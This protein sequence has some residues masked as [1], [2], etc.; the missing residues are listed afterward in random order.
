MAELTMQPLNA[1]F[2]LCIGAQKAGTVWLGSY[3]FTHPQ[4]WAS[5]VRALHHFDRLYAPEWAPRFADTAD[6]LLAQLARA[7]ADLEAVDDVGERQRR[8]AAVQRKREAV[9]AVAA[10]AT[11]ED[12]AEANRSYARYFADRV[13]PGC[14][15]CGEVTPSYALVPREGYEAI[16]QTFPDARFVFVLRDPVDRFWSGMQ[17]EPSRG[18]RRAEVADAQAQFRQEGNARRSRYDLTLGTLDEV[19]PPEQLLTI[20]YEDVADDS[21]TDVLGELTDFLGIEPKHADRSTF[22]QREPPVQPT[23]AQVDEALELLAPT[24]VAAAARFDRLP[25]RWLERMA[26]IGAA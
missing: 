23:P 14:A 1:T 9:S 10:L 3:L 16:L 7:E 25:A 8:A 11:I 20:F 12:P 19:V 2:F 13:P 22:A 5:P 6:R 18:P 17:H 24:Y 26:M 21:G 4:V 15:A